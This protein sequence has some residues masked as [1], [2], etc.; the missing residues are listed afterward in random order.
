[1][2]VSFL[3]A[4]QLGD[5]KV[6]DVGSHVSIFNAIAEGTKDPAKIFA[7]R[8]CD[9][10]SVGGARWDDPVY[11]FLSVDGQLKSYTFKKRD[12]SFCVAMMH[13]LKETDFLAGL[14]KESTVR[15]CLQNILEQIGNATQ[16]ALTS[17][18]MMSGVAGSLMNK[19]VGSP[20]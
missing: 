2:A 4:F 13:S 20:A 11:M 14:D 5:D 15:A 3:C 10:T 18:K 8:V 9:G 7:T 6:Y 16:L 1:M 12:A 17:A 19:Q